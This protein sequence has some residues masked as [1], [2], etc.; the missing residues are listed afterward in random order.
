MDTTD[1]A[2]GESTG[3]GGLLEAFTIGIGTMVIAVIL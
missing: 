2:F 1:K 3:Y